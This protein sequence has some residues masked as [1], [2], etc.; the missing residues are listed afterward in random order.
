MVK[1]SFILIVLW[2]WTALGQRGPIAE[3][4]L[5]DLSQQDFADKAFLPLDGEWRMYEGRLLTSED[6]QRQTPNVGIVKRLP[7]SWLHNDQTPNGSIQTFYLRVKIQREKKQYML[8]FFEQPSNYKVWLNGK[9]VLEKG[10]VGMSAEASHAGR[11]VETVFVMAENFIDIVLQTSSFH[12]KETGI[13][14][15][16][17]ISMVDTGVKQHT[18]EI[19]RDAL[20]AGVLIF[21]GVYN[22]GIF[23]SLPTRD[24]GALFISTFCFAMLLRHLAMSEIP[25][26]RSIPYLSSL[27]IKRFEFAGITLGP[28]LFIYYLHY[29]LQGNL[30]RRIIIYS[31]A[32]SLPLTLLVLTTDQKTFGSFLYLMQISFLLTSTDSFLC[33]MWKWFK[34][35][36]YAKAIAFGLFVILAGGL[37]DVLVAQNVL[38]NRFIFPYALIAFMFVQSYILTVRFKE[39]LVALSLEKK[40]VSHAFSQLEKV[41][42][43]H[44]INLMKAGDELEKTMPTSPK[45][46]IVISFDIVNSSN[47]KHFKL[48]EFLETSIRQCIDILFEDYEPELMQAKGYR[49]KEMGD[50]FLCSIGYPFSI[51]GDQTEADLAIELADR[52][53]GILDLATERYG[54][55]DPVYCGIGIAMGQLQGYYPKSGTKEYDLYGSGIIKATRYESLR[56]KLFRSQQAHSVIVQTNIYNSISSS[57][58][59][60]F[61]CY[62]MA[63]NEGIR[64]DP[65]AKEFYYKE[66]EPAYIQSDRAKKVNNSA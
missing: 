8:K 30:P 41:F 35:V 3:K 62:T 12:H 31:T 48:N 17:I 60:K 46:G 9:L 37:H 50:G 22:I 43:P 49:I 54:F 51:S 55:P 6:L 29:I 33:I 7:Q 5:I 66:V 2:S 52:F 13:W 1:F 58:R 24:K 56:K 45:M 4:G 11:G 19:A 61:D 34:K 21:M 63:E 10:K 47:L 23:L 40:R 14:K 44:Q 42:Y 53:I 26:L 59:K 20:L 25:I 39:Y 27:W 16:P 28:V 38:R 64:D 65:G 15:S 36:N 57:L 18:I 32:F